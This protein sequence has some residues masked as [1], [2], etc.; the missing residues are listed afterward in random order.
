MKVG[1]LRYVGSMGCKG[2]YKGW[3][4][5]IVGISEIAEECTGLVNG[6]LGWYRWKDLRKEP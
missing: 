4:V 1:D 2:D 6:K 3:P 5:L